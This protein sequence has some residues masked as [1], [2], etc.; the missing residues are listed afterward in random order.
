MS[1]QKEFP[2]MPAPTEPKLRKGSRAWIKSE[3]AKFQSLAAEHRGLTQPVFAALALG[4]SRQR[5]HQLM[6]SGHL[7]SFDV[8][9]KRFISCVDIEEFSKLERDSS[10]RYEAA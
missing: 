1:S 5:I 8:M 3:F 10:F 2:G 6:E 9:G 4:V 7:R